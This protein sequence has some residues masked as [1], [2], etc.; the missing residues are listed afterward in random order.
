MADPNHDDEQ[1]FVPDGVDDSIPSHSDAVTTVFPG[2]LFATRR[3]RVIGQ[4]TDAGHNTLTVPLLVNGLYLLGR[5]RLDQDPISSH[6][7]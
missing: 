5:R 1:L 4:R 3:P 6:A 7:A 2:E